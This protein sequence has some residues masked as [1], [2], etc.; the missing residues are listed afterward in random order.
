M[1]WNKQGFSMLRVL[2]FRFRSSIHSIFIAT[3]GQKYQFQIVSQSDWRG[4]GIRNDY[5]FC[6][7]NRSLVYFSLVFLAYF[8]CI[9]CSWHS[10]EWGS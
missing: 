4:G 7:S 8:A 1:L 2:E 9:F 10:Q 3:I 6:K 5:L